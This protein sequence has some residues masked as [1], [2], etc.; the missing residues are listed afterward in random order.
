LWTADRSAPGA[1]QLRP[2]RDAKKSSFILNS[3]FEILHS[4]FNP[5]VAGGADACDTGGLND[6]FRI[7]SNEEFRMKN[8]A[9]RT[10]LKLR[11]I[12]RRAPLPQCALL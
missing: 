9:A 12:L 8:A 6:E 2:T 7:I 3:S 4:K 11:G 10:G 1:A 5:P